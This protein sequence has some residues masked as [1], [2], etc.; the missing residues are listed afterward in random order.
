M[1][2][3]ARSDL[4]AALDRAAAR[5][6]SAADDEGVASRRDIRAALVATHER[7]RG[8]VGALYRFVD[9]L[10]A[11][12]G[13]EV[14]RDDVEEAV[15]FARESL[16]ELLD[17]EHNGLS[18]DEVERLSETGRV[19]L[20]LALELKSAA[21][22]PL[23]GPALVRRLADLSS[24]LLFDDLGTEA[25]DAALEVAFFPRP[26][27]RGPDG[28]RLA[29]GLTA[30]A[31]GQQ[32]ARYECAQAS[33]DRLVSLN[34]VVGHHRPRARELVRELRT[35]L[36]DLVLVV[37]GADL[38]EVDPLHPVYVLGRDI[39]GNLVGL[40]SSVVWT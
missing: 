10:D 34:G 14:T 24:G 39:E 18:G 23:S 31:P 19:A 11:L 21:T 20:Q 3:L 2:R 25:T 38:P 17:L 35:S 7:D 13:A 12:P 30:D 5:L 15:A 1:S 9:H 32:L 26:V 16:G 4:N 29:L 28:V 40:R 8:L 36:D 27:P 6:L 37:V 33:L 22:R